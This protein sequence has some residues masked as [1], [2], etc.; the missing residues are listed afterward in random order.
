QAIAWATLAAGVDASQ[1]HDS[2]PVGP[3]RAGSEIEPS[4][5]DAPPKPPGAHRGELHPVAALRCARMEIAEPAQQDQPPSPPRA[6]PMRRHARVSVAG[7]KPC[8]A[9]AVPVVLG[10][11]LAKRR[12]VAIVNDRVGSE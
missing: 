8:V 7:E 3:L 4:L 5:P 12:S 9:L 10:R 11:Q 6:E 1:D 2:P